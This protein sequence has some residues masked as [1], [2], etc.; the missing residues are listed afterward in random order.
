MYVGEQKITKISQVQEKAHSTPN[1]G[2]S[3]E[4]NKMPTGV[5]LKTNSSKHNFFLISLFLPIGFVVSKFRVLLQRGWWLWTAFPL[6]VVKIVSL[7]LNYFILSLHIG[8]ELNH[9]W[10]YEA[11][12]EPFWSFLPGKRSEWAS[13]LLSPKRPWLLFQE[14]CLRRL[15]WPSKSVQNTNGLC[16]L[17]FSAVVEDGR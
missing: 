12:A 7:P 3:V 17:L 5:Y 8:T 14:P 10:V 11:M 4:A 9:P 15:A 1:K 2:V 6:E 13:V 16:W